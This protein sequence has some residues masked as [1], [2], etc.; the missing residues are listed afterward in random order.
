MAA[1]GGEPRA[2]PEHQLGAERPVWSPDST[3]IAYVARVPEDG[4]YEQGKDARPAGKE[5][6]RHITSMRFRHD[7]LGFER[8]RPAH[9]FVVDPFAE[10]SDDTGDAA[11]LQVTHTDL[12]HNTPTWTSDGAS[13]LLHPDHYDRE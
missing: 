9:V 13:L 2:L 7:G 6:P 1:D 11:P 3:R 10:D 5:A 4:R 8:D 12:G